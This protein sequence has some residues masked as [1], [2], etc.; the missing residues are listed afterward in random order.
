MIDY[1]IA[2]TIVPILLLGWLIVQLITRRFAKLHPELG[3]PREEG[4]GCGKSCLCSGNGCQHKGDH[5]RG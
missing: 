4:S 1:L 2:M 3:P 5:P